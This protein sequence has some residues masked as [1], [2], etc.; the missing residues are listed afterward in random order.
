M[1]RALCA[2]IV[3]ALLAAAAPAEAAFQSCTYDPVTHRVTATFGS[4]LTGTL[5][6]SGA[7]IRADGAQCGAATTANTETIEVIGDENDAE[8]LTISLAGGTFLGGFTNEPGTSDEVEIELDL[9]GPPT[10]DEVTVAGS[11]SADHVTLGASG[12]GAAMTSAANLNANEADGV[13]ADITSAG[14]VGFQVDGAGGADVLSGAGGAGTGGNTHSYRLL[15]GP[16]GDD[17]TDTWQ[18]V[19]G[20]G[21]DTVRFPVADRGAVSYADAPAGIVVT[22]QDGTGGSWGGATNDGEGGADVFVGPP[23][24]VTGSDF[25]DTITGAGSDDTFFGLDGIDALSGG[26]GEDDLAGNDGTDTVYGGADGDEVTGGAGDDDVRG[27]GGDDTVDGGNGVDVE[28]GGEG[29][30]QL[31]QSGF[32]QFEGEETLPNGADDISGGPGRD[33]LEYGEPGSPSFGVGLSGRVAPVTVT[34]DD[35]ANDGAAGEGDNAHSDIEDV[36]G[37]TAND[38]LVGDGDANVLSGFDGADTLRGGGGADTLRGLGS[39]GGFAP[40]VEADVT[41][42][43]DDIDGGAGED[44][45]DANEGDDKI[46]AREGTRDTLDCGPGADSGGGDAVDAIADNCEFKPVQ[47]TLPDPPLQ[48]PGDPPGQPPGVP[49]P[50][51]PPPPPPGAAPKVATLLTLPSTRRCASR[52][53]FTVRVRREIRGTVSRVQIFVN[54]KRVKSVT[55]RRIALPIDLRGLPKGKVKVRLRVELTDGR[56]ATDTRTYRTCATKKRRGQFGRRRSR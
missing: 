24:W 45:V 15:G 17:L 44:T 9:K 25:A 34:L 7:E 51:P 13:D 33:S 10:A 42:E 56:V 28:A 1:A 50:P 19:P 3:L 40:Q 49:P 36:V 35:V 21:N 12:T 5:S 31:R 38:T 20:P 26:A 11:G 18:S 53:K 2:C 23:D 39:R 37:G 30:D 43:G 54:G 8:K 52:R 22:L 14:F 16:G 48:P 46:E 41:D 55:G 4:G 27:D 6:Q 47:A 29:D 32:N